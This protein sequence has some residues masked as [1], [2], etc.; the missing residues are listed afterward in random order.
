MRV[1]FIAPLPD[2]V[3]G[4][5]LACQVLL[6]ELTRTRQAD[7]IDMAEPAVTGMTGLF[8]RIRDVASYV[9]Q[10]RAK[11]K[12]ADV[13]YFNISQSIAGNFKDI[14]IYAVCFRKLP[15]M[16]IH[17]HGGAGMRDIMH[18]AN[19]IL[20]LLNAPF[21]KRLGAV[22]VLGPSHV[23]IFRGC[24]APERIHVVPNFAQDGLFVTEESIRSKFSSVAPLRLLFLSNLLPGKGYKELVGAVGAMKPGD[25]G[26]VVVDFAGGFQSDR[27]RT[28][29]MESI[30][31]IP[32]IRYHGIVKGAEKAR[33]LRHA[34]LFCLPTYYPYEG[35]PISILEAYASGCA[36]VATHHSGIPDIFEDGI[37]GF[38]VE[39]RS[40]SS[41]QKTIESA[42]GHPDRLAEIA[43]HNRD[44]ALRE[45]REDRFNS[46]VIAVID[47]MI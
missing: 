37:N 44:T 31:G 13:I 14:L 34:H 41:L 2:P 45:Y 18:S 40:V 32:E 25:R 24:V 12:S 7:V 3:T 26:R 22:I 30:E 47:S 33:L 27:D 43:R 17:L 9:R 8:S 29:F 46:A 16:V 19:P 39:K 1:L 6:N 4:Q 20:R 11:H 5:S 10:A 15:R 38:S 42:L 36:V 23:D 28:D 21:L 35:Q